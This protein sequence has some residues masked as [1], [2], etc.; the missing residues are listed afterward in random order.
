L[1]DLPRTFSKSLG[2]GL[3]LGFI[4]APPRIAEAVR[5]SK[6]LLN[7]GNPWLEQATLARN[8]ARRRISRARHSGEGSLSGEPR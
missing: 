7:N 4:A 2:A 1:H 6:A 8:D 5:T 3:R